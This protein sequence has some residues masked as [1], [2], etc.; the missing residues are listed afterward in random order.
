MQLQVF[1]YEEENHFNDLRTVEIDGEIWFVANDV[2]KLLDYSNPRDAI[3][4]HCKTKGVVKHD[5]PSKSGTQS[6]TLLNEPNVYRLI[7]KSQLPSAERFEEWLFE[8]VLPSIRKTGSYS[9]GIN[10]FETP[11]FA[12]R[13]M[14][15]FKNV[16]KGYFSVITELFTR[17]YA[18]LEHVGYKIPNKAIDGKEIRPDVSVGK[19]FSAYLKHHYPHVLDE[20]KMYNHEFPSGF[21]VEAREYPID[22]LPIFIKFVD[23]IWIP[24][25]AQSYFK[26]RDL[27]AI[28]YL[29]KLLRAS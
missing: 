5:I 2:C 22:Y 27:K 29:P 7:V 26:D 23:D 17:L 8:K 20:Y 21:V 16:D 13:Y 12:I 14:Q 18:Q 3:I 11:N 9:D 15:N 25:Y 19:C 1:K 10:R 4:R 28:D 6:M 24:N